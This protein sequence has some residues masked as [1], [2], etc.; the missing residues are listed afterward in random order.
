MKESEVKPLIKSY[1]EFDQ[2]YI[3][4]VS[5]IRLDY[6]HSTLQEVINGNIDKSMLE[7]SMSFIEEIRDDV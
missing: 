3:N 7:Q 6:V 1:M 2:Q 4:R 5:R